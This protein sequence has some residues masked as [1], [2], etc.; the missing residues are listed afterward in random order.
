M[1]TCCAQLI[2]TS[3][4]PSQGGFVSD[5]ASGT[6]QTTPSTETP[7]QGSY[8][9]VGEQTTAQSETPSQAGFETTGDQTTP[10]SSSKNNVTIFKVL[11]EGDALHVLLA[12]N[13]TTASDLMDWK[14]TLNKGALSYIFPYFVLNPKAI[15]TIHSHNNVD[16]STDLY[17]SNFT[18]N[19]T[20][21]VE[22]LNAEGN[23]VSEYSPVSG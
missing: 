9:T 3:E 15:V 13:G 14:L 7:S 1:T 22:L 12:N 18:W 6:L 5:L 10:I 23:L 11:K 8:E 16:T 20:Q 19:G 21:D 17:G 2:S 4:T